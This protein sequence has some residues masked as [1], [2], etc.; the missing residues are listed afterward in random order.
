MSPIFSLFLLLAVSIVPAPQRRAASKSDFAQR[1]ERNFS[2]WEQFM[3]ETEAKLPNPAGL[4]F[5][6][7]K[8][9]VI[10]EF[11]EHPHL[12][13]VMRNVMFFL[14]DSWGLIIV[15]GTK[16]KEFVEAIVKDWGEVQL[17]NWGKENVTIEGY[18][19]LMTNPKLWEQIPAEHILNFQTDSIM[20]RSGID[21]FLKYDY[22]GAPWFHHVADPN[23][24]GPVV[25]N[26]GFSLRHRSFMMHA[27]REHP[28]D[29][30]G[31]DNYY[32]KWATNM[33]YNLSTVAEAARFSTE[34]QYSRNSLAFHKAW[35]YL[36]EA[37]FNRLLGRISYE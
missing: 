3:Q 4:K 23:W 8:A 2:R 12:S 31:E 14:D 10:V 17:I 6:K 34:G 28:Y 11:R 19:I 13:Y 1:E 37:D 22:I 24:T 36:S 7:D 16:N 18:S 20:C 35:R 26:G 32:A 30:E 29:D 33:G 21:R 27:L 15:H 25:G 5:A 9:A